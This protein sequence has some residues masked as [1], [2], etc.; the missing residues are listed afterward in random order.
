MNKEAQLRA[1]NEK[2]KSEIATLTIKN[3]Q[4]SHTVNWYEEQ[5]RLINIRKYQKTSEGD[6]GIYQNS[7]FDEAELLQESIKEEENEEVTVKEHSRK[8][9][10]APDYSKM[11][12]EVVHRDVEN[13]KGLVELKSTYKEEIIYIPGSSLTSVGM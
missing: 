5:I 12:L 2:L 6:S 11:E 13:K 7:L 10:T 9:K 4:L 8:K 3:E 1:E